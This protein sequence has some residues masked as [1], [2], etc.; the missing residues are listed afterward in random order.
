MTTNIPVV[1]LEASLETTPPVH[2]WPSVAAHT[3]YWVA[4]GDTY[5]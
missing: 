1:H 2:D 4:Y 5:I 3:F